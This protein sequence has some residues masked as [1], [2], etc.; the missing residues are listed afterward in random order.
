MVVIRN[1]TYQSHKNIKRKCLLSTCWVPGP[2]LRKH[3]EK[4]VD[5]GDSHRVKRVSNKHS[6]ANVTNIVLKKYREV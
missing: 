6:V 3:S 2:V 5:R 4:R 1:N